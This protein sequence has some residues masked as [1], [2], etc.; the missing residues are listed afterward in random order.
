MCSEDLV[1]SIRIYSLRG[2]FCDGDHLRK[3]SL[4]EANIYTAVVLL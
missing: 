4:D 1:S 3:D 2:S